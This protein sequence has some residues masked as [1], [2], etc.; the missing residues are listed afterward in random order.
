MCVCGGGQY[1]VRVAEG[2]QY[3]GRVTEWGVGAV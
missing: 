1:E 2:G 3:E